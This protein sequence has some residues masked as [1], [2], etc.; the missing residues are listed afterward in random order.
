MAETVDIIVP[1]YRGYEEVRRCLESILRSPSV[2]GY[3]VVIVDDATPEIAVEDYLDS[4]ASSDE[5]V[6]L[7]RNRE[8][9]GFVGSVN[10]GMSLHADHDVVLLNSDTEVAND[11]LDRLHACAYRDERTATVTPFSNNATICSFPGMCVDNP[12]ADGRSIASVDRAMSAT[13][14]G[15][16]VEIPTAVGFCMYIK[17]ACLDEIGLFDEDTFGRGYGEENDFCVRAARRGWKHLLCA[18]TFV[19]HAGGVSFGSEQMERVAT[20]QD[21]LDSMYPGYHNKIRVHIA[22]DPARPMRISALLELLRS[23]DKPRYLL[24]THALAGGVSKHVSEL[25]ESFGSDID[26]LM[27]RPVADG[28]V[29]F[30]PGREDD[31]VRLTFSLPGDYEDLLRLCR[32]IGISRIHVHHTMGVPPIL[33]W[34]LPG[35]LDIPVDLTLHDYY[36]INANPTLTDRKGRFCEERESRDREC[37][38]RYPIPGGVHPEQ[39]RENQAKLLGAAD[40]VFIPSHYSANLIL[41][42]FP[43]LKPVVA[44]H[45]DGEADAPYPKPVLTV[46]REPESMRILVVGAL[47]MEKG[48]GVLEA[49]AIE[50]KRQ[51]APLEFH[52]LGYAYRKIDDAVIQHGAYEDNDLDRLITGLNPHVIWF[53]V[54]WPETY[55]YTL[56]AAL[57][58]ARPVVAPGLGA[59]P[60]RLAGRPLSW[61]ESWDRDGGSWSAYFHR[62]RGTLITGGETEQGRKWEQPAAGSDGEFSYRRDYVI[63]EQP[64][65]AVTAAS[66]DTDRI[67]RYAYRQPGGRAGRIVA[68]LKE[69]VRLVLLKLSQLT[70]FAVILRFVPRRFLR[71]I[72]RWLSSP[73]P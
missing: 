53:P 14:A 65:R 49:T 9:L 51:G 71:M 48:G 70:V 11:W 47:S 73:A 63:Q 19:Y 6:S 68:V 7:L 50:A 67:T 26:F 15:Q 28:M 1:V 20:A 22:R 52:L 45:P 13:N 44:G 59:F 34:G 37:A 21:M 10:R 3:Q 17:R 58:T 69:R 64:V 38:T 23:S 40:R 4:L 30:F 57:R 36:V 42:Y 8:N 29:A 60:E 41:A 66:F 55:S 62:L 33:L 46:L 32:S 25:V 43:D 54:Q 18:D 72:G 24:I 16:S 31:S 27:I 2:T 35:D 39:W 61:L 56:S 12:L 5:R